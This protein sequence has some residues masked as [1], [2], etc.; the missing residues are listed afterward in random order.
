MTDIST[1]QVNLE[2]LYSMQQTV[3][4]PRDSPPH[5]ARSVTRPSYTMHST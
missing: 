3:H 5:V 4:R 2:A 1:Y